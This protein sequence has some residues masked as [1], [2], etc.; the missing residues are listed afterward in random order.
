MFEYY[1]GKSSYKEG[2]TKGVDFTM[3]SS[4]S[5]TIHPNSISISIVLRT[6]IDEYNMIIII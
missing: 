4:Y 1:E 6:I 2:L 5:R 3:F